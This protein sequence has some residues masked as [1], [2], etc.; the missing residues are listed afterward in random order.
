[1]ERWL[2]RLL[3]EICF[4]S[5]VTVAVVVV[6]VDGVG[7]G[8]TKKLWNKKIDGITNKRQTINWPFWHTSALQIKWYHTPRRTDGRTT[9]Q[10]P[11][12]M[13]CCTEAVLNVSLETLRQLQRYVSLSMNNFWPIIRAVARHL[14]FKLR[15]ERERVGE[16]SLRKIYYWPPAQLLEYFFALAC[17]HTCEWMK[18]MEIIPDNS[19][20]RATKLSI[21]K[22]WNEKKKMELIRCHDFTKPIKT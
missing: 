15:M 3:F 7:G 19:T 10:T 11:Y 4:L 5:R 12:S 18:W 17:T 22:N 16:E 21:K 6:V 14:I 8:R 1:M 2:W 13:G 9:G 20:G